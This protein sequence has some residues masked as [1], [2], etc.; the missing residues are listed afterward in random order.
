MTLGTPPT[1]KTAQPKPVV[2]RHKLDRRSRRIVFGLTGV[3]GV[4]WAVVIASRYS[5]LV[6]G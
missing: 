2:R 3:L 6:A 5:G 4:A 1:V